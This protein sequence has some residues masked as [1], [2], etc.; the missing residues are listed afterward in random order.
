MERLPLDPLQLPESS[1]NATGTVRAGA[2]Q[3]GEQR[4]QRPASSG[5]TSAAA[6]HP[7]RAGIAPALDGKTAPHNPWVRCSR[8]RCRCA[9]PSAHAPIP[10]QRAAALDVE[11]PPVFV[12]AL[13]TGT[14]PRSLRI[15]MLR[16]LRLDA[17][18]DTLGFEQLVNLG[19]PVQPAHRATQGIHADRIAA[20]P[21]FTDVR[22]RLDRLVADSPVISA[23]AAGCDTQVLELEYWREQWAKGG[24]E[25]FAAPRLPNFAPASAGGVL[26]DQAGLATLRRWR[27][28]RTRGCPAHGHAE[29]RGA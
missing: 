5:H 7:G 3:P 1:S 20:S 13:T 9:D 22:A 26:L 28:A 10:C 19:T 15:W 17:S 2:L 23:C 6:T 4:S 12:Q 21:R 18:R 14:R 29:V 11:R 27:W 16:A 8:S 25:A 24:R